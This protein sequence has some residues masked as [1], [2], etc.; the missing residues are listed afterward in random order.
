MNGLGQTNGML[1]RRN[2]ETMRRGVGGIIHCSVYKKMRKSDFRVY[3]VALYGFVLV[4]GYDE[5]IMGVST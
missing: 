2:V 4:V 3:F 5:G 1:C